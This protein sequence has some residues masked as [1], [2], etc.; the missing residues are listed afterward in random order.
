MFQVHFAKTI[1][2]DPASHMRLRMH[3]VFRIIDGKRKGNEDGG[4][5]AI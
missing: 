5:I 4:P 3:R 2:I 1:A